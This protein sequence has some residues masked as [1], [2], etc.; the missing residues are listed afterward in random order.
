MIETAKKKNAGNELVAL[1]QK[2]N[3]KINKEGLGYIKYSDEEILAAYNDGIFDTAIDFGKK[4][5]D[6]NT[7]YMALM[8]ED[9]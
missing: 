3:A 8:N 9:K 4:V 2:R 7:D 6:E 1:N 5:Y